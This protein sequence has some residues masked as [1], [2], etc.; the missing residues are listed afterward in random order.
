MS[1]DAD[2]PFPNAGWG[3]VAPTQAAAPPF[4]AAAPPF[5]VA[6]PP[7]QAAAPTQTKAQAPRSDPPALSAW[8]RTAGLLL[9][10]GTL[11][12]VLV[13]VVLMGSTVW[14]IHQANVAGLAR[15]ADDVNK[16]VQSLQG[17]T[18]ALQDQSTAIKTLTEE[19]V[20][21]KDHFIKAEK[22]I[23]NKKSQID[24]HLGDANHL[25]AKANQELGKIGGDLAGKIGDY[26]NKNYINPVGQFQVELQRTT[27]AL[28]AVQ[29]TV[30]KQAEPERVAVVVCDSYRLRADACREPFR[31]IFTESPL[32][33]AFEGYDISLWTEH[34]G[35]LSCLVDYGGEVPP[36]TFTTSWEHDPNA[37]ERLSQLNPSELFPNEW[38][39][40]KR[41]LLV[42]H[43]TADVPEGGPLTQDP[44][45]RINAVVVGEDVDSPK[46][47]RWKKFCKDHHGTARIVATTSKDRNFS[48]LLHDQ[49]R[50]LLQPRPS[51]GVTAAPPPPA[52]GGANAAQP[53]AAG[54]VA[55]SQSKPNNLEDHQ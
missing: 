26:L 17:T 1:S 32:R 31:A 45:L 20:T 48:R 6:A 11:M 3:N 39:G 2:T 21:A 14:F 55:P 43:A 40:N 49:A 5:Q 33:F 13:L 53:A 4:Q 15:S 36:G 34:S 29:Q 18:K 42:V 23:A 27:A 38:T 44:K 16:V 12:V 28:N 35:K 30:K 47:Q 41:C 19:I 24:Q 51:S 37:T 22:E 52:A 46:V 50:A 7:T 25:V 54:A 9:A 8:L 10:F